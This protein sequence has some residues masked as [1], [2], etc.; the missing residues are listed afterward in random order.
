LELLTNKDNFA[1]EEI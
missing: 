1:L